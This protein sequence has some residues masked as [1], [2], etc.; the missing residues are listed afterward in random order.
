M[1][2][3]HMTQHY[4]CAI[5]IKRGDR[6]GNH[7]ALEILKQCPARSSSKPLYA[8]ASDGQWGAYC[9][10]LDEYQYHVEI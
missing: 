1:V 6:P 10:G 5:K 7:A 8:E 3:L 9:I 4:C 2:E